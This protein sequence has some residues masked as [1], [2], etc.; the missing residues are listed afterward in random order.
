MRDKDLRANSG[1]EGLAT[2][3]GY[4][5]RDGYA[6]AAKAL[7]EMDPAQVRAEVKDSGLRG[8]GG[9]GFPAGM[10]WGFVP[11]DAPGPRY[12]CVNGDEGEP[13]T[14]KDRLILALN[15]HAVLE[16]AVIAAYAAGI[17]SAFIY[18]RGEYAAEADSLER[19]IRE[20]KAKGCLGAAILGTEFG[21]EV[22]VHR[23]AGSYICGEETALLE[24]LEGKRGHPRLKPPFPAAKG[25][26]G[27]PTVINNVETLAAVPQII[28]RGAAWFR[29]NGLPRDP[30]TRLFSVSGMVRRPGVYELPLGTPLREIIEHW[31]GGMKEGKVLK[32]VI[33]GG[34]SAPVL[35]ADEVDLPMDF[36]SVAGAG[37]MLGSAAVI[38]IDEL[39]PMLSVLGVVTRFYAHES[40]GQCTPCRLG[41]S[42]MRKTVER[43]ARG[44]GK[45]GDLDTIERVAAAIP[46][47]TLCPMG[48][49]AALPVLALVR[50][51]RPELEASL[52]REGKGAAGW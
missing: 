15:P 19:A 35:R 50:K 52:R 8:R 5:A 3:E 48:E 28:L 27:C 16:G 47:R 1:L 12:L 31:A 42:W 40:C 14:F 18:I 36:E 2:L 33:P 6:A 26:F 51:F 17:H 20:A 29:R 34:L 49:A 7:R 37:S 21:L 10:K 4:L 32:A 45:P 25:L 30:G 22:A 9:A 23:G 38:V 13:G 46:G 11:R 43:L 41:T 44:E 39:T 24:S